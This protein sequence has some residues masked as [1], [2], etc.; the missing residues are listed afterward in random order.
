MNSSK[1]KEP[2]IP[3][4]HGQG[5]NSYKGVEQPTLE[6]K[7]DTSSSGTLV[8]RID[9]GKSSK[10]L[11]IRV[12]IHSISLVTTEGQRKQL[13]VTDHLLELEMDHRRGRSFVLS[14]PVGQYQELFVEI[15]ELAVL[16]KE[17]KEWDTILANADIVLPFEKARVHSNSTTEISLS[18][19]PDRLLSNE[20]EIDDVITARIRSLDDTEVRYKFPGEEDTI[21]FTT[22]LGYPG[23]VTE[24][25]ALRV[26]SYTTPQVTEFVLHRGDT[27]GL[28]E[29]FRGQAIVGPL[30]D[31]QSEN[32]VKGVFEL[33]VPY[34]P[35]L[36]ER[37]GVSLQ[38]LIVM[39]VDDDGNL[40]RE[41][42]PIKVDSEN[43]TL[44]VRIHSFSTF[45]AC[46]P[47]IIVEHPE[48]FLNNVDEII[49]I[50]SGSAFTITGHT[51]DIRA[52]VTIQGIAPTRRWNALG[53]FLFEGVPFPQR[54]ATFLLEAHI[55]G[56][57][58]HVCEITVRKPFPPKGITVPNR[59]YGPRVLITPDNLPY[60]S[61]VVNWSRT[62]EQHNPFL[63]WPKNDSSGWS[64]RP[65]LPDLWFENQAARAAILNNNLFADD[66]PD[67]PMVD[68]DENLPEWSRFYE[69][70]Q[71]HLTGLS[72]AERQQSLV[73]ALMKQASSQYKLGRLTISP[74]LP[75]I[76]LE[77][78]K[79]GVAF[80]VAT[81]DGIEAVSRSS[82]RNNLR[83]LYKPWRREEDSGFAVLAG[84]L[85]Y[86]E[87]T[88]GGGIHHEMMADGIWCATVVLRKNPLTNLPSIMALGVEA[89]DGERAIS[90][91]LFFQK[92]QNGEWEV[93]TIWEDQ[94]IIDA[95]FV[96][97]PDGEPRVVASTASDQTP[98][99][100]HLHELFR[101]DT[102]WHS[103]SITW[104]GVDYN[105]DGLDLGL[106]P[107]LTIDERGRTVLGFAV[108]LVMI[109]VDWIICIREPEG[110]IAARVAVGH[111]SDLTGASMPRG[112][113][114]FT[115]GAVGQSHMSF[116]H[117]APT[118][119]MKDPGKLWY[120]Y[121]NGVL[122]LAEIDLQ[123]F[124]VKDQSVDIDRMTGFYPDMARRPNGAVA[125]VYKDSWGSGD[126]SSNR[127]KDD[128]FFF[129][130][131][132][133]NFVP[134]PLG[135]SNI[136][137]P[138]GILLS[139][140][141]LGSFGQ[142]HIP[143][144]CASIIG[145]SA[146][147]LMTS[148]LLRRRFHV[149]LLPASNQFVVNYL[150][151]FDRY[152]HLADFIESFPRRIGA[153]QITIDNRDFPD[154][155]IEEIDITIFDPLTTIQGDFIDELDSKTF[156]A[157]FRGKANAQGVPIGPAQE[158]IT[159]VTVKVKGS[160]WEIEDRQAFSDEVGNLPQTFRVTRVEGG[161]EISLPPLLIV[162]DR[163]ERRDKN[164]R[165]TPCGL[166]ELIWQRYSS[167]FTQRFTSFVPTLPQELLD[168]VY[169]IVFSDMSLSRY[170]PSP[171]SREPQQGAMRFTITIPS[172]YAAGYEGS[173]HWHAHFARPASLSFELAPY[174]AYNKD[175]DF[176]AINW[177]W[178][179]KSQ[180][181]VD[182]DLEING[183]AGFLADLFG[184]EDA[185]ERMFRV[186]A[187][188]ILTELPGLPEVFQNALTD[189]ANSQF[190]ND[191]RLD[192]VFL[193]GWFLTR[194]FRPQID[195]L[196]PV[197]LLQAFPQHLHLGAS[198]IGESPVQ[199]TLLLQS[200]GNVPVSLED[201]RLENPEGDFSI[202]PPVTWP[203]LL[204]PGVFVDV[205]IA[206]SPEQPPGHRSNALVVQYNEGQ[207]SVIPLTGYSEAPPRA[208]MRLVPSQLHFG[209]V[210]PGHP[211][212]REI[213]VFNDSQVP[214]EISTLTIHADPPQQDRFS[215]NTQTPLII[216]GG[217]R[218][219][220]S[221]RYSPKLAPPDANQAVLAID[222]NDYHSPRAEAQLYGVA[223]TIDVLVVP[224]EI[225]FNDSQLYSVIIANLPANFPP[226]LIRILAGV[227]NFHI[228]NIG[229]AELILAG[230]SFQIQDANSAPSLHFELLDADYNPMPQADR[231]VPAGG[232]LD[233]IV[234]FRPKAVG[235]HEA[236]LTL[237]FVD[238]QHPDISIN[239]TGR[240]VS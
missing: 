98:L 32:G 68:V 151:L 194:Y 186:E 169:M 203:R 17:S 101:T 24:R 129:S 220:I 82:L 16:L 127:A 149:K 238:P 144:D 157:E 188:S 33:T 52:T 115:S 229:S 224:L 87:V 64:W 239:I 59:L 178:R 62:F 43:Q 36:V 11:K 235:D 8:L 205:D 202:V 91:L 85:I 142:N 121:G 27:E 35:V 94:P 228:H 152:P 198:T 164:G 141:S 108:D 225:T 233:L 154:E 180:A 2:N 79:I 132:A 210:T 231:S 133:S 214:L 204:Q 31:I 86:T 136:S 147:E 77:E 146:S 100:G 93:Q 120:A 219:V 12:I 192:A 73:A 46:T 34:D 5:E 99:K 114:N 75:L 88:P 172:F 83:F 174:V 21:E 84:Q 45:F 240:G 201:I 189:W 226:D 234:R 195:H 119:A 96:F 44:T 80:V 74:T 67:V 211:L 148:I 28:P 57:V 137:F 78:E 23:G 18:L 66:R 138:W 72:E 193:K 15:A 10:V 14:G 173:H 53:Q 212:D 153:T 159:T 97:A 60:V 22:R 107:R 51:S 1:S 37:T 113:L 184:K 3:Q 183:L 217:G 124:E 222:S 130:S 125:L 26:V 38:D 230:S 165:R 106:W 191:P 139:S 135:I 145:G 182:I 167:D 190:D 71:R 175:K 143:L 162:T 61:V 150:R 102:G 166:N 134:H 63:Y 185:L 170:E 187:E 128:L 223:A 49:G 160:I 168:K 42:R 156:S 76:S 81:A 104:S 200:V 58:K 176:N 215:L 207:N 7:H 197:S 140:I 177:Y 109:G 105:P 50:E 213:Q 221:L 126:F 199:R 30:V 232:S 236:S 95:D 40:F 65:L 122:H 47:G 29:L 4:K 131:D 179:G 48:F 13:A 196:E 39:Q 216:G 70:L 118:L 25:F 54:E 117:W 89:D 110:W 116:A 181:S 155:E 227:R 123:T 158:E 19:D 112:D 218:G 9:P 206:F 163:D 41:L 208:L 171:P 55:E 92:M 237:Q 20:G 209:V 56:L 103:L 6:S 90:R 161:F 69:S 111:T